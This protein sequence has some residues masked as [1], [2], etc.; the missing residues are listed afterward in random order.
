VRP[1]GEPVGQVTSVA[2]TDE[3]H[4]ALGKVSAPDFAVGTEL[5]IDG[6]PARVVV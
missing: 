3:G 1:S 2:V 6:S 4:F 5:V